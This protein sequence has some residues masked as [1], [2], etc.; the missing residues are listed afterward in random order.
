MPDAETEFGVLL[1][2][3]LIDTFPVTLPVA[4]GENITFKVADWPAA[5]VAP[6]TPLPALNPVPLT[7]TPD[8]VTLAFPVFFT[9]TPMV[10]EL[11]TTWLP[12]LMLELESE[13]VRVVEPPLP[14]REMVTVG[15]LPLLLRTMLPVLLPVVV[16]AKVTV[17]FMVTPGAIHSG[18]Y[19]LL[20]LNP[21]PLNAALESTKTEPPVFFS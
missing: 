8:T 19:R 2:L 17:K 10:F 3:L 11:P 16:G 18:M 1:A 15:L 7:L 9:A 13:S 14:L 6:L 4:F 20:I 21:V 12:K 5:I